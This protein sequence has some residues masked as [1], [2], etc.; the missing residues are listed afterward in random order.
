VFEE[1]ILACIV[2]VVM[3]LDFEKW[4][5]GRGRR[6]WMGHSNGLCVRMFGS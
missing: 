5:M 1:G 3:S 4:K 6:K 2:V